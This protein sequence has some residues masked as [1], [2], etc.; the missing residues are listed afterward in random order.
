[1]FISDDKKHENSVKKLKKKTFKPISTHSLSTIT[2]YLE[3]QSDGNEEDEEV[4]G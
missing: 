3:I 4:E 2:N 1:M